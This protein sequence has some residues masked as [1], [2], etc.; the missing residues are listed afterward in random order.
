[1]QLVVAAPR[2]VY[3]WGIP[4][5]VMLLLVLVLLFL[6]YRSIRVVCGRG[7]PFLTQ[8][9][10]L[11]AYIC[12]TLVFCAAGMLSWV[13]LQ[14]RRTI[15]M[16]VKWKKNGHLDQATMDDKYVQTWIN[17]TG[18]IIRVGRR[19]FREMIPF[20]ID[21]SDQDS[22][23]VYIGMRQDNVHACFFVLVIPD[24]SWQSKEIFD[25]LTHHTCLWY[26]YY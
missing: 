18:N 23:F 3:D 25:R 17:K 16:S 14:L 12:T 2:L 20:K 6:L 9:M 8:H 10:H 5:P 15:K 24:D 26:Y 21:A 1:M 19:W 22:Q 13:Q 7:D 4:I 11:Y